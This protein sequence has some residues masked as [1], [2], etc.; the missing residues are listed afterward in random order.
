MILSCNFL[1]AAD[2]V[3]RLSD[4]SC[5]FLLAAD[6]VYWLSDFSCNFLLAADLV[7]RL[8]DFSC[9]D[10]AM[11]CAICHAREPTWQRLSSGLI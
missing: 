5:N 3:Y 9:D 7:Y 6:F 2:F 4:F 1:L 11:L 10:D 8:S